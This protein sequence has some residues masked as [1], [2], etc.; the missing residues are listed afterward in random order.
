MN[1]APDDEFPAWIRFLSLECCTSWCSTTETTNSNLP[2]T[3]KFLAGCSFLIFLKFLVSAM[4]VVWS[5]VNGKRRGIR[6]LL[7]YSE[8]NFRARELSQRAQTHVASTVQR[9]FKSNSK[10]FRALVCSEQTKYVLMDASH[11]K[12]CVS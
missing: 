11:N 8:D 9:C 2:W 1:R 12:D 6:Q 5:G 7:E 10:Q 3:P 4:P